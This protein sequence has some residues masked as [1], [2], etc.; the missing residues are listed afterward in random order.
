[1]TLSL[2]SPSLDVIQ[3]TALWSPDFPQMHKAFAIAFHTYNTA[4]VPLL[5]LKVKFGAKLALFL[6]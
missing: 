3:H 4:I 2:R 1:M 5:G 6:Y